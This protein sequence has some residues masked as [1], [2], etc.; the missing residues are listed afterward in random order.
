[1]PPSPNEVD[2]YD[3]LRSLFPDM[4]QLGLGLI[5]ASLEFLEQGFAAFEQS[6]PTR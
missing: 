1:M 4:D 2:G 6:G 5:E 3:E